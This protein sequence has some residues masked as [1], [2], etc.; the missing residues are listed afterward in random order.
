M[1]Y[2]EN[3][4]S[5]DIGVSCE[6]LSVNGFMV[7]TLFTETLFPGPYTVSDLELFK[8]SLEEN[9]ITAVESISFELKFYSKQTYQ[10]LFKTGEITYQVK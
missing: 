1:L 9:G 7:S 10:T 3:N 6:S 5:T 8:S 2:V 4:K